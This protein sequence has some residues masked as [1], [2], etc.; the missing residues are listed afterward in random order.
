MVGSELDKYIRLKVKETLDT[1]TF[2]EYDNIH[3]DTF[4][5]LID[6]LIIFCMS[7]TFE[8]VK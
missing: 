4:S 1:T 7:V 8:K 5:E 6:K 2:P 3:S